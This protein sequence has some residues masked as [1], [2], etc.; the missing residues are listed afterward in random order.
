M[1]SSDGR[2]EILQNLT[3]I[4]VDPNN[5]DAILS[6][7][8]DLKDIVDPEG[9]SKPKP[10]IYQRTSKKLNVEPQ[11]CVVFEDSSAGVNAAS[12]AGMS[13]MAIPNSYTKNQDFSGAV[14]ITTF[15]NIDINTLTQ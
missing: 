10:Y 8:D 12:S 11:E 15:S 5:F 4:G 14:N 1:A 2:T 7:H 13:V 3:P 6:G 9:T